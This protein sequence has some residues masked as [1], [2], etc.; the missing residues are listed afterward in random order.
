[1]RSAILL[2]GLITAMSLS[3]PAHAAYVLELSVEEMTDRATFVVRGTITEVWTDVDERGLVWTYAQV[4]PKQTLK[5]DNENVLI[6]EQIGGTWADKTTHV[7]GVPRFS[8]GEDAYFFLTQNDV[9]GSIHLIGMTQ[10]KYTVQLDPYT[11]DE[12]VHRF[13]VSPEIP[14]DHRFI[15]LPPEDKR[16]SVTRFEDRIMSRLSDG[17]HREEK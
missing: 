14:F 2:A 5:G 16:V 13:S 1:M 4:E 8:V 11:Q 9:V 17:Q 6:I 7:E 10:G 15:P 3:S 12:I